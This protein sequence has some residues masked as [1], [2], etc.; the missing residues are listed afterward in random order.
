MK[1]HDSLKKIHPLNNLEMMLFCREN[2][3]QLHDILLRDSVLPEIKI[4]K[5][6]CY[7]LNIGTL[8]QNG[9]HWTC[10]IIKNKIIT[11]FDSF[12]LSIPN[13]FGFIKLC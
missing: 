7:I 5:P 3:I 12:G 8:S 1:V 10:I 11:Y 9:T 2:K 6:G 4:I 13:E